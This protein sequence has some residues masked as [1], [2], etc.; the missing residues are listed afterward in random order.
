MEETGANP[1]AS[2]LLFL[3]LISLFQVAAM[4]QFCKIINPVTNKIERDL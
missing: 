2:E 3:H 4:Q 1:S